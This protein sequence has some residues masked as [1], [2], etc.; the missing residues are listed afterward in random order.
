MP[1]Y[2]I[3]PVSFQERRVAKWVRHPTRLW[4]CIRST[5]PM[6]RMDSRI[7]AT[8]SSLP[9]V[10]TLLA[11]N[12]RFFSPR[13][14]STSPTVVS[15]RPYIGE[16]SITLPPASNSVR[17]TWTSAA[18]SEV[19]KV[20]QVPIPITGSSSPLRGM[21]RVRMPAGTGP[22]TASA[23]AET[24]ACISCLRDSII[25]TIS[26]R[27]GNGARASTRWKCVREAPRGR[28]LV[29]AV[30]EAR[31]PAE[32][33]GVDH[34]GILDVGQRAVREARKPGPADEPR[35]QRLRQRQYPTPRL[36]GD[37][38]QRQRLRPRH[39]E[40]ASRPGRER[41]DDRVRRVVLVHDVEERVEPH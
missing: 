7:W 29:E 32:Q 38:A 31:L 8:P 23:A 12:A 3:A 35:Q 2:R 30:R 37:H 19:S 21:G 39:V 18:R 16:E 24:P 20:R 25:A 14:S 15:E 26:P 1:Q 13:S 9:L 11:R 4:I 27:R 40:D 36:V 5:R 28:Q 6:R 22:P 17:T 41:L 33:R 34:D 10:Q